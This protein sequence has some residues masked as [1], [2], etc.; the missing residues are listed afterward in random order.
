M[1]EGKVKKLIELYCEINN[2]DIK[3]GVPNEHKHDLF[4]FLADRRKNEDK[5]QLKHKQFEETKIEN[6]LQTVMSRIE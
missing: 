5:R 2:I 3:C 4:L 1:K 6:I